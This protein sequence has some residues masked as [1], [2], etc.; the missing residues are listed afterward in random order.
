M[1]GSHR[2]V[3]FLAEQIRKTVRNPARIFLIS[4]NY[5]FRFLKWLAVR[6]P[7]HYRNSVIN[8]E[9]GSHFLDNNNPEKAWKYFRLCLTTSCN[10]HHFFVAAA[11]LL[12][13]LGRF[14]DALELLSRAN[15]LRQEKARAL[16]VASSGIRFLEPIWVGAFGHLAQA[17][18][19]LKLGI[20][21]GRNSAKTILYLPP[22]VRVSNR[23]LLDLYRPYLTIVEREADLPAPL[24]ALQAMA[25]DLLAPQ[26]PDGRT[27]HLWEIA[28]NTYRRWEAEGRKPLLEFPQDIAERARSALNGAGIPKNAWFVALHVREQ[29]SKPHH[30]ELHKV[31][32]AEIA[33]Y[34]PAIE[35]VTKRG[36]WVIRMGDSTMKPIPA[37]KNVFDYCHSTI[38]T[39]WMD[40]FLCAHARFLVG[41]SSGPAYVPSIFGVASVLTNWWPPAQRPWHAHD[42]FMPK[43]YRTRETSRY[44]SLSESLSEPFGYCNSI[45]Y[46]IRTKKVVLENNGIEDIR[47]AVVEM[48]ERTEGVANY[49][50][51]DID[52]R[53]RVN[54]IFASNSNHGSALFARDF[55]KKHEAILQ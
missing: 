30:A 35:E 19:L 33:D 40:V 23:F 18:Y 2:L 32:N 21:E 39:D 12:V 22:T 6:L 44:F 54:D 15:A 46:L 41:T 14:K 29:T 24:T 26:L 9:R 8:F 51:G 48:I 34:L 49:D 5:F 36:G 28:A 47:A 13:G 11:C 38:R 10:P 25:F 20:L 53:N 43:L 45:D 4:R 1:P 42:I 7:G 16:N 31:L 50:S 52:R 17:D 3:D 37:I 27:V 55:L